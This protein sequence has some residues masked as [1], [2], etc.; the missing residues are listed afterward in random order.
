MKI[1]F[2]LSSSAIAAALLTASIASATPTGEFSIGIVTGGQVTVSATTIDWEP[3]VGG[4]FGD[5][6]TGNPTNINYNGGTITSS[7]NAFGRILD[8]TFAPISVPNFIQFYV[9]GTTVPTPPGNA[10]L[11][12]FP[13]F[14]L[15]AV[16]PGGSGQGV[17]NDCAG[18]TAVGASCSP[19]IGGV[20]VSPFV[21]TNRPNGVVDVSLSVELLGRD[22][23]GSATWFGGFT[24]QL[25]R[26]NASM[27]QGIVNGGGSISNTWSGT[28]SSGA[29][30]PEPGTYILLGSGLFLFGYARRRFSR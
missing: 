19:M 15:T 9:T 16:V 17:L 29:P 11:Q 22:S 25:T 7:T 8:L 2:S 14:D 23:S 18:V 3:P 28:F 27:V 30:I 12:P 6:A 13:V 26:T 20:F 24:T 21:L 10:A 5:F 1:G 4:G